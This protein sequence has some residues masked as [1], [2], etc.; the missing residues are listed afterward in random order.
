[1]TKPAFH[2]P[3]VEAWRGPIVESIMYGSAA[4]VDSHG[5]LLA[6]LG[7]PGGIT[8]L[9]SSSKPIQAI[10]LVERGGMDAYGLTDQEL[11]LICASHSGMDEHAAVAA[12]I[13]RKAGVTESDLMCG[14]H[15]P[16][17]RETHLR[18]TM[19]GEEPTSNRHNCSG[20]HSGM[21]ALAQQMQVPTADYIQPDHPIQ[22][23]ILQTFS[24]MSGVPVEQ[25]PVGVDGCSVP[26]FAVPMYNGALAFARLCDPSGLAE[27][28]AA[29]CRRITHAMASH[30]DMVAGPGR[31]DTLI[32]QVGGGRIISKGG[33]EGY[34]AMGLLPDALFPGSPALGI[35]IK[36]SDGD[37]GDYYTG[38]RAR[39]II[40]IEILQQLGAITQE[41]IDGPLAKLAARPTYNW[42]KVQIGELRPAAF[43]L[44]VSF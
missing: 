24:E 30:P 9:R 29:A 17:H 13:Q 11:A 27:N 2:V 28:R 19:R 6:A 44:A 18:M 40:S 1:M 15:P 34:Q 43:S 20:K 37:Q 7:D 26:V 12:S 23:V 38:G 21:L 32:M 8:Y 25:I 33:A 42:R 41:E 36:I 35:A 10:P 31:F 16:T 22:K 39:S 14:V 5:R 4:I 3:L